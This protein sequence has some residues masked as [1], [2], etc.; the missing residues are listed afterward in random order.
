MHVSVKFAIEHEERR[1]ELFVLLKRSKTKLLRI[2]LAVNVR[3]GSSLQ[4][5]DEFDI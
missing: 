2:K 5:W 4:S 3:K 1:K